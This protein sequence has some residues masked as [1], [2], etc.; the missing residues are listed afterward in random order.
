MIVLKHRLSGYTTHGNRRSMYLRIVP[1][2]T[3][4]IH[5]YSE[6]SGGILHRVD[7]PQ[8]AG[9]AFVPIWISFLRSFRMQAPF[10]FMPQCRISLTCRSEWTC[11]QASFESAVNMMSDLKLVRPGG[12]RRDRQLMCWTKGTCVLSGQRPIP[13]PACGSA[14]SS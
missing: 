10:V 12:S 8:P 14:S 1:K 11:L 4:T 13:G 9:T 7:G 3:C 2:E 5:R 6:I